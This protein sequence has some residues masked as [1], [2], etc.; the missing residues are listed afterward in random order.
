[1][2]TKQFLL[3]LLFLS[4][5]F[6]SCRKHYKLIPKVE[7]VEATNITATGAEVK[8]IIIDVGKSG[9]SSY[10]YCFSEKPEPTVDDF[11]ID[12]GATE[13]TGDYTLTVPGM[14][15]EKKY[16]IRSFIIAEEGTYYG[17]QLEVTT[18]ALNFEINISGS[19]KICWHGLDYNI[20][21]T[22]NISDNVKIEL[23]QA[24]TLI[25]T[26]E[27]NIENT[28]NYAWKI[29]SSIPVGL[30][31]KIVITSTKNETISV[32]TSTFEIATQVPALVSIEEATNIT[33]FTATIT[34][35]IENF[36]SESSVTQHGH[37]WS[38]T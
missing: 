19:P 11:T 17:K 30:D 37:C 16:Y 26:L 20:L 10:G 7:T 12:N 2:K 36:G 6:Y 29:P 21:W 3:F 4:V 18:Q 13:Q 14:L 28:G 38:T 31:Y 5:I 23:Y 27:E 8:G 25:E 35:T 32:E 9:I 33:Y 24:N 34:G 22:A 1:M 15:P